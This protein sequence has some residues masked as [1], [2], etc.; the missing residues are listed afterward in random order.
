MY[1]VYKCLCTDDSS[2]SLS[3]V[4]K[5]KLMDSSGMYAKT[6]IHALCMYIYDWICKMCIVRANINI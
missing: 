1:N 5:H 6:Y 3:S 4:S 2:L